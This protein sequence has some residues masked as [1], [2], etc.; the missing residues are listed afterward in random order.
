[1]AV[2]PLMAF[3]MRFSAAEVHP[4]PNSF[5]G[6]APVADARLCRF[7]NARC[8]AEP[9]RLSIG[10]FVLGWWRGESD[11]RA[12]HC[13]T[14]KWCRVRCSEDG[15]HHPA[16]ARR[17]QRGV[18]RWPCR[19]SAAGESLELLLVRQLADSK[20]APGPLEPAMKQFLPPLRTIRP[21]S[22]L[23][24]FTL[25]E[26]LVVIAIIAILAALLLPSLS[27]AKAAA[28]STACKNHLRQMGFALKIYVDENQNHYPFYISVG[29]SA[30]GDF[31]TPLG[32]MNQPGIYWSSR[33][34]PYYPL[35]WTN[36]GF[37][38]PAYKGKIGYWTDPSTFGGIGSY[39]YNAGGIADPFYSTP[40]H[41]G[42][43][44][45]VAAPIA[46][47]NPVPISEAQLRAPSEMLGISDT[48]S[49][50]WVD[51]PEPNASDNLDLIHSGA[52]YAK[53]PTRHGKNYNQVYCDGHVSAMSLSAL[54]STN[55]AAL[56][57][58]DQIRT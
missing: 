35:H 24:A 42:L 47:P 33:L 50:V 34:V 13:A 36:T 26:L 53:D 38:C 16:T 43:G 49:F 5:G 58:N 17:D 48:P 2:M 30:N 4:F 15:G 52:S 31:T 32:M 18:V 55:N 12:H 7:N 6:A 19:K 37:H 56:W 51:A 1:M 39:G 22:R 20:P 14:W 21:E 25:I 44:P 45:A 29:G 3:S 8:D 10:R 57:N 11:E 27:K 23:K 46:F 40:Q 28:Q 54:G 9:L 41:L